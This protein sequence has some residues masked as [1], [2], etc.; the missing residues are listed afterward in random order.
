MKNMSL[1][2][3]LLVAFLAVGLIP[4]GV[5][6]AV[7]YVKSSGA[8]SQQAFGQLEGVRGIKKNQI[9]NFFKERQGDM[10]VLVETVGTLRKE[11]FD[12]TKSRRGNQAESQIEAYFKSL[13]NSV[14][15]LTEN[16]A[17]EEA[18]V[19]FETSL[20]PDQKIGGTVW[21]LLADKYE[22]IFKN[23]TE[24]FGYYDLFLITKNGDVVYTVTKES[25]F[26]ENLVKGSLKDSGLAKAFRDAKKADLVFADFAPYAP[27]GGEPAGFMACPI[28]RDGNFE[29]VVAIQI[30][31]NQVND[32][33]KGR[34]GMG[35]TGETY[36]VGKADAFRFIS[37]FRSIP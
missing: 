3:K 18:I 24:D 28:R 15:S 27:S 32:I 1:K 33:M 30:P 25:D 19:E 8:L 4:F 36:L 34:D 20:S 35:K 17:V 5:I 7:S 16:T 2:V 26:G 12:K 14:R 10:G 9:E 22:K 21:K 23:I 29:G 13:G 11:S 6:A 31:L 37:A